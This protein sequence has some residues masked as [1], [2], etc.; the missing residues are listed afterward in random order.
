MEIQEMIEVLSKAKKNEKG[1]YINVESSYKD[2]NAWKQIGKPVWDFDSYDYRIK[3]EPKRIAL[4]QQDLIE[5]DLS[6][7]T[8]YVRLEDVNAFITDFNEH[9]VCFGIDDIREYAELYQLTFLDG[10]PCSKEADYE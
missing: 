3:P 9:T 5:R 4:N 8:M 10:T 2:K 6:G 1:E 7:K